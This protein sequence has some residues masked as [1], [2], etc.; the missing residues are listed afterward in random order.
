MQKARS[1]A[2][3][4]YDGEDY[5]FQTDSH[6]LF[7]KDWDRILIRDYKTLSNLYKSKIAISSYCQGYSNNH[8]IQHKW[9]D[10]PLNSSEFINL[11]E[12]NSIGNIIGLKFKIK[13][14]NCD[15]LTPTDNIHNCVSGHFIFS[16]GDI[17][18][19]NKETPNLSAGE[20][21][22]ISMRLVSSGFK[23]VGQ[24]RE[25]VKH[26]F[27]HDYLYSEDGKN[28]IKNKDYEN[29]I[30]EYPRRIARIDFADLDVNAFDWDLV[31]DELLGVSKTKNILFNNMSLQEYAEICFLEFE[32]II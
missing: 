18:K 26:L 15:Y 16:I 21:A 8:N 22:I 23:V 6:M 7:R 9:N 10:N 28:S 4:F 30:E 32:K 24:L 3:S 17:H 13:S 11:N 14:N 1:A 19:I 2:N 5:Y 27:P 25:T 31:H 12:I 20:E 29:M